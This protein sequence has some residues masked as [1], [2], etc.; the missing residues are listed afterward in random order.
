[1][2]S[3]DRLKPSDSANELIKDG[4]FYE[5][6]AMLPGDNIQSD[7]SQVEWASLYSGGLSPGQKF[8]LKVEEVIVNGKSDFQVIYYKSNFLK[9]K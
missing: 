9:L 7:S 3:L 6:E 8:G 2:S 1:M 5:E 4:W